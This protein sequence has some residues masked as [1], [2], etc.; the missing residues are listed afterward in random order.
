M[1]NQPKNYSAFWMAV[2]FLIG[3]AWYASTFDRFKTSPIAKHGKDTIVY[4]DTM[5]AIS[6]KIDTAINVENDTR[7][8]YPP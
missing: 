3:F 7:E 2:S 1:S 4:K 5:Y 8:D 6:F